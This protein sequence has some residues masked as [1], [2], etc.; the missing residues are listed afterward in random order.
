MND[1]DEAAMPTLYVGLTDLPMGDKRVHLGDGIFLRGADATFISALLLVNTDEESMRVK[2]GAA[3][4]DGLPP[5]PRPSFWQLGGHRRSVTAELAI[6]GS[7]HPTFSQQFALA[8]FIGSLLRLWTSPAI[9]MHAMS[10][11][12]FS[13]LIRAEGP[14][15]RVFALES[16]ERHTRLGV[17]EM[18]SMID[19]LS[20]VQDNWRTAHR[21]Y[22]SSS[23]FR[24]A[25]DA[26]DSAQFVHNEA[27][28]LVSCWAAMEA[29]FSPS[30]SE[31][32]FRVSALI[33][34]FLEPPG[35]VGEQR[36]R[37]LVCSM[38]SGPRRL[39]ENQSTIVP[40]SSPH[41]SYCEGSSSR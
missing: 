36:K 8:R 10:G 17:V 27:L 18:E 11:Q 31:L 2:A 1:N 37:P 14:R 26:L 5:L 23:E 7:I 38:T 9:R 28:A 13:E 39:T 33:A 25:A 16:F 24:L 4:P 6:P 41:S 22:A 29:L 20:W 34:S 12:P 30:T 3:G 15:P 19:S 40:T 32:K 35:R 21:L